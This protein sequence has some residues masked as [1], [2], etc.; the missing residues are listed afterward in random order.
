MPCDGLIPL[1]VESKCLK[2]PINR[3]YHKDHLLI[4]IKSQYHY[5]YNVN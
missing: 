5:N 2:M 4:M 3:K 1:V